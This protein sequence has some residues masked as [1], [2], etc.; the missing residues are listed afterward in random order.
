MR[1]QELLDAV[2]AYVD[3]HWPKNDTAAEGG[4]ATPG[5]GEAAVAI[6]RFIMDTVPDDK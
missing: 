6:T 1:K 3:E 2:P 4:P 5:R